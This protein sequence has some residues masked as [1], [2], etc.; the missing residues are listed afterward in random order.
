MLA[1][2]VAAAIKL[3]VKAATSVG[4]GCLPYQPACLTQPACLASPPALLVPT[5]NTLVLLKCIFF[6]LKCLDIYD[7]GK[8]QNQGKYKYTKE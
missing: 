5:T 7:L 2:L 3:A 6:K 8:E 4:S 1:L